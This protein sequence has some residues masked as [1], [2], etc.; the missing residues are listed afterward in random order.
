MS[1]FINI[2]TGGTFTDG[3]F[4]QNGELHAVKVL[5]TPHDLTVCLMDCLKEGARNFDLPTEDMLHSAGI[6][7]YSTTIG[8][9]TIIQ[10][11][12]SKLGL[13]VSRGYEQ[14]LYRSDYTD[15]DP[16]YRLVSPDMIEGISGS[17]TDE[18]VEETP[19]DRVEILSRVQS[20]IDRGAQ[21][22]VISLKNSYLNPQHE[23]QVRAWVKE[24]F[25]RYYLSAPTLLLSGEI[26]DRPGEALRTNTAVINAYIHRSM[27][28]YLYKAEEDLRQN[29]FE[30]PLLIMHNSG[31]LARV[32][33]T[34]ALN[35]YNSGPVGGLMGTNYLR[36]RY[37]FRNVISTDMGG[38]SLDI[39]VIKDGEFSFE[40]EPEIAGMP[41]N[42]PLVEVDAIGA[43][44]GSIARLHNGQVEVGPESAGSLPGP[45]C[46]DLGGSQPTVTDA[47]LVLGF[48]D[49]DYF[50]GGRMKLNRVRAEDAIKRVLADP[51][52]I[53]VEEAAALLKQKVDDNIAASLEKTVKACG[54][55][56][57][58]EAVFAYGGAG[59][60]HCCGYVKG[61]SKA[62]IITSPHSPVFSAF[63]LGTMDV[64][65]KYSNSCAIDLTGAELKA[66]AGQL[67]E[68]VDRLKVTAFRDMRGEGF[69]EEDVYFYL[70]IFGKAGKAGAE[71]RHFIFAAGLTEQELQ[72]LGKK[73]NLLTTLILN[74]VA[75]IPHNELPRY[76]EE[77][78]DAGKALRGER[79]VFW[80]ERGAFVPT[81]VFSRELLRAGNVIQGP[82][83]I[84]A[85]DTTCVVPPGYRFSVD[86]LLNGIMEEVV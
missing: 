19:L 71:E 56:W 13:V 70:E 76:K 44:G 49:P 23:Q 29:Y 68:L 63:G 38:T 6:V 35:T 72:E 7:R 1:I 37:G 79:Q 45:A 43:G 25:P 5:T 82:A 12:G 67:N 57:R 8:T 14:N 36:E 61:L 16:I 47:D 66:A 24:E 60:T 42:L 55:D 32:A 80:P 75:V 40:L 9:N 53:S 58:P 20:L 86:E 26:S 81:P 77:G 18:G 46:F 73:I 48:L 27:A 30:K 28:R 10:E 31:G 11:S 83:I 84:E 78:S 64:L 21:V 52:N 41:I 69:A 33:K 54:D 34:R 85:V 17:I 4:T 2:D 22:I 65:H 51:L 3:F 62:K 74:A 39:G 59:P 50:L 15:D